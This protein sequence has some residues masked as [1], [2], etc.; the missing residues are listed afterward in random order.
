LEIAPLSF[1]PSTQQGLEQN[2]IFHA[3]KNAPAEGFLHSN[4]KPIKKILLINYHHPQD[5]H[6]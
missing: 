1:P 5:Q 6:M 3:S 2:G 4:P